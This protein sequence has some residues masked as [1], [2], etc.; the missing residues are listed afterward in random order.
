MR[1]DRARLLGGEIPL[2]PLNA[3][4]MLDA[5]LALLRRSPRAVLGPALVVVGVVQIAVT[6]TGY[7]LAGGDA[8]G[9]VT[10]N[11]LLR[12]FGSQLVVAVTGGLVGSLAVLVLAGT[13]GPAIARGYFGLRITPGVLWRDVR[14]H[15]ARLVVVAL[16]VGLG[17]LAAGGV[18][19]IPFVLLAVND[20]SS[21]AGILSG[22]LGFPA[23]AAVTVWL[24]VL[25]ALAAPALVLE[26]RGIGGA[27][28]RAARLVRG[29]WWKTF[30]VLLLTAVI[31][32]LMGTA[33]RLPFVVAEFLFFSDEPQGWAAVA[34]LALDTVGRICGAAITT[35]FHAGVLA[36]LYLDRRHRREGLDLEIQQRGEVPDEDPLAPWAVPA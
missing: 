3:A 4:E 32:F 17:S 14:P 9:E 11:V 23:A 16:I 36:L 30:L 29:Q 20:G 8:T 7:F 21:G 13:F 2:R 12:S 10:P 27:L 34:A 1:S 33:L 26:R 31:V 28:A 25:G 24:Y 15:L 22:V 19:L 35:P 5:A 6:L 18:L